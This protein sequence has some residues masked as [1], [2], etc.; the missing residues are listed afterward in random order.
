MGL[1]LAQIA[2]VAHVMADPALL[3][4]PQFILHPP[5]VLGQSKRLS[6]IEQ[7]LVFPPPRV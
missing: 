4:V 3:Y 2:V 5:H 1:H 6:M 7:E